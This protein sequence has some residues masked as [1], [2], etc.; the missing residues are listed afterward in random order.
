MT[1]IRSEREISFWRRRVRR[2]ST[3][4]IPI[5][6]TAARCIFTSVVPFLF[7]G[8]SLA[9]VVVVNTTEYWGDLSADPPIIG[10][11]NA[12]GLTASGDTIV[13]AVSGTIV[14]PA[15]GYSAVS[16]AATVDGDNRIRLVCP[17]D[18]GIA[19]LTRL[20]VE[21]PAMLCGP[22]VVGCSLV[23][24]GVPS[25][26]PVPGLYFWILHQWPEGVVVECI[27]CEIH[28]PVFVWHE[29]LFAAY[30]PPRA[31]TTCRI[32]G[33]VSMRC[34]IYSWAGGDCTQCENFPQ[35]GFQ[36][37][38]CTFDA[39][40]NSTSPAISLKLMNS[41]V[42][43]CTINPGYPIGIEITGSNNLIEGNKVLGTGGT[44]MRIVG[45]GNTIGP[46]NA[47]GGWTT[48]L[49][50]STPGDC[51]GEP[52]TIIS[53]NIGVYFEAT[54]PLKVPNDI[55]LR[56]LSG[57]SHIGP[58]NTIIAST[59][60]NVLLESDGNIVNGNKIGV[61][62]DGTVLFPVSSFSAV[63]G[64]LIVGAN[65][66]IGGFAEEDANIIGENA[67][68]GIRIQGSSATGNRV[69][70]NIVGDA[71]AEGLGSGNR[72][73]GIRVTE[74]AHNNYVGVDGW[75]SGGTQ[76]VQ[77]NVIHGN[78]QG[79]V[80]VEGGATRTF[81]RGN[82]IWGHEGAQAKDIRVDDPN[83]TPLLPWLV[84]S[85]SGPVEGR[86]LEDPLAT[87]AHVIDVYGQ[88]SV[89]QVET[90]L[91]EAPLVDRAFQLDGPV[92]ANQVLRATLTT[93]NG[94]T[95]LG[96]PPP[97]LFF[98]YRNSVPH[99][100]DIIPGFFDHAAML[101][102]FIPY[103]DIERTAVI[104]ES[105]HGEGPQPVPSNLQEFLY[106]AKTPLKRNLLIGRIPDSYVL[107]CFDWVWHNRNYPPDNDMIAKTEWD[108]HPGK[109][110][111]LESYHCVGL[112][113]RTAEEAGLDITPDAYEH[114][115]PFMSLLDPRR[116]IFVPDIQAHYLRP[117]LTRKDAQNR[118]GPFD[119]EADGYVIARTSGSDLLLSGSSD[120]PFPGAVC[121]ITIMGAGPAVAGEI[122]ALSL[123][124][125]A[126]GVL[127]GFASAEEQEP[128]Q[129]VYDPVENTWF[130]SFA[131]P[132]QASSLVA[133]EMFLDREFVESQLTLLFL[134]NG[135][136][137]PGAGLDTVITRAR[138]SDVL[139]VS[140]DS[141][142]DGDVDVDDLA[143]LE[144]CAAGPAIGPP[145]G[146]CEEFDFD[147]DGDVDQSDF[148]V[149]Q[150][151]WSGPNLPADPAC[152]E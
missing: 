28:G 114:W 53:N 152:A 92:A 27:D 94:T 20:T 43:G 14:I 40:A 139:T 102:D 146:G 19:N 95:E 75:S 132:L 46:L 74:F 22:S 41:T 116:K 140:G 113:E 120:V 89:E 122:D 31:L 10:L 131:S 125:P 111:G 49:E 104:I 97:Q 29:P 126:A 62:P 9:D 63:P 118:R 127:G 148:G 87:G 68:D 73:W 55:G 64:V 11:G 82:R 103:E 56:A 83:V 80:L 25:Y 52:N 48:G 61:G 21:A 137:V 129:G 69:L 133:V 5:N 86:C 38:Q 115:N 98:L 8:A 77:G 30:T 67:G 149:F 147:D 1:P 7:A 36:I 66:V 107:G 119:G 51:T 123:T 135:A 85:R 145:P 101:F 128:V 88:D 134:S 35:A 4:C 17:G 91:G 136:T 93:A 23:F 142:F 54:G 26:F 150:R 144:A 99:P 138:K 130:F 71:P 18:A 109:D 44:G 47:I 37:R 50:V 24:S 60:A 106:W 3:V 96:G 59:E 13:F 16:G 32:E 39:P 100:V 90:Y 108:L 72:G 81:I 12:H 42:Q 34:P 124:L 143:A 45:D 151:C 117:G 70:G 78:R 6:A 57:P 79:G 58:G 15:D 76:E 112:T 2:G 105:N 121:K 141:D 110:K 33:S 65:N 84:S